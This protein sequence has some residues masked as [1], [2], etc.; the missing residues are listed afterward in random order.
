MI[1]HKNFGS[2]YT[3]IY[4]INFCIVLDVVPNYSIGKFFYFPNVGNLKVTF[5][6]S[7]LTFNFSIYFIKYNHLIII[8]ILY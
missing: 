4:L 1:D 3:N 5:N 7:N 2:F 6:L 8:K